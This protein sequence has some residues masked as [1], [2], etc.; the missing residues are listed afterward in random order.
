M[1]V[2][3][4]KVTLRRNVQNIV[5]QFN[6][7]IVDVTDIAA[8]IASKCQMLLDVSAQ[9]Q[10]QEDVTSRRFPLI[11]CIPSQSASST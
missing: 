5:F 1:E 7:R 11:T 8:R 2:W 9:I 3:T 4:K 10:R 6:R